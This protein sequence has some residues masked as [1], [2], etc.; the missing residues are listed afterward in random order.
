MKVR[1]EKEFLILIILSIFCFTPY[2][3]AQENHPNIIVFLVDDMGL[4]DTSVPFLEDANGQPKK[5]PLNDYYITPNMEK[6]ARQGVCFTNFYAHS[7]CSPTRASILTGQNSARHGTTNWINQ[8][9][10]NRTKFGPQEWNWKGLDKSSVT[11]PRLLQEAGYKTIHIGKAHFGPIGFEGE[12]PINLGFDV[13][14]GGS[15]AGHPGSYYGHDGY[16]NLK[17]AKS[18]AVAGLEKYWKDD[19]FLTEAL[20][21]EANDKITEAQKEGKPFFLYM[22]HYAVHAP[23]HSDPRFAEHYKNS[24]KDEKAQAYA[25]LIEGM[26]KSL[27]DIVTH[28]KDLG[29]GENTLILFLGDNGSDAPLPITNGYSSSE[30]LRG[31]KGNHWEGGM[32]VPFIA[33]WITPNKKTAAQKAFKIPQ[34]EIQNQVGTVI[35]IFPTIC[36]LT[37]LNAPENHILDGYNLQKQLQGKTNKKRENTF[38]NH[39]P[40]DVH[41]STYFTSF[42][43][44]DWKVIYFFQVDGTPKYELYYTKNDPFEATNLADSNPQQLKVMMTLLQEDMDNK[45][46]LYPEKDGQILK[47]IQP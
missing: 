24:G 23:F 7:V 38:L 15:A 41:R 33:S 12:N 31:K 36:N 21:R 44:D 32:R 3:S 43:K 13:N 20:T 8:G 29:L 45:H 46:A 25:T 27:G 22:S 18:H 40:H 47:I 16:G 34:N 5:Y 6:L 11:L 30:P 35:D 4:M 19:L 10:N 9:S 14:V 28:V 26:D 42:V 37:H 39:F 2:A 1:L 17:G